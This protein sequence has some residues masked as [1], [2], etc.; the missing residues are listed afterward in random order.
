MKRKNND[1]EA[2]DL[3]ERESRIRTRRKFTNY[4]ENPREI[5]IEC[6]R[7]VINFDVKKFL[8]DYLIPRERNGMVI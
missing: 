1:D 8:I 6:V 4:I 5:L 7:K 3:V 2:E